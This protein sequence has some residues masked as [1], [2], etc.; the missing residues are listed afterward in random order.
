M[1]KVKGQKLKVKGQTINIILAKILTFS[2]INFFTFAFCF[3]TFAFLLCLPVFAQQKEEDDPPADVAAPPL[4][5]LSTDE[6]NSL[7]GEKDMKKRTKLSLEFMEA[8]LIK[9]EKLLVDN[10][11][12]DSLNELGG[13]HAVLDNE[14]DYLVKN[15]DRS[16]KVDN[17]F[18]NFEIYLRKQV[19]RLESIR[20]EMPIKYG[21]YVG[22]LMKAV[23]EARGRCERSRGPPPRPRDRAPHR[24]VRRQDP[25]RGRTA[26][27]RPAADPRADPEAFG[28][29]RQ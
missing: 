22:K 15:N 4:K 27:P 2:K 11:F 8:R 7:E 3:F 5:F 29:H 14:L 26:P 9:S 16:N 17:N 18:K 12:K 28:R 23:R 25:P 1:N 10:G 19:P 21:Y 6:K 13:F 24:L 20:R